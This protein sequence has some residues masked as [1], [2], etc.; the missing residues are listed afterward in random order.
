MRVPSTCCAPRCC[1]K[2]ARASSMKVIGYLHA[3][4]RRPVQLG[5]FRR[6]LAEAGYVEGRD[7]AIEYRWAEGHYDRLPAMAAELVRR[8]VAVIVATPIPGA[9][10]AKAATETIPIVFSVASDP[11]K[12]GLVASIARPG[13]NATGVNNFLAELGAKATSPTRSSSRFPDCECMSPEV[14]PERT[15]TESKFRDAANP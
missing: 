12:L 7:V 6:G 4:S 5:A 1:K 9:L 10:A 14:D 15:K 2:M 8:Q 3:G 11:V 13:G